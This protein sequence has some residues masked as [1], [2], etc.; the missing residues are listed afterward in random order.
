MAVGN[1]NGVCPGWV[2]TQMRHVG[3]CPGTRVQMYSFFIFYNYAARGTCLVYGCEPAA[4]C[5]QEGKTDHT[6]SYGI[7]LFSLYEAIG[8]NNLNRMS[9]YAN[10]DKGCLDCNA[11][12]G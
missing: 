8:C 5:A 11:G 4:T 2:K 1:Y 9:V 12:C 7:R 6:D 10:G 3:Q